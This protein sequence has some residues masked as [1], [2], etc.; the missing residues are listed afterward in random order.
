MNE[1]K[2]LVV[3]SYPPH[4]GNENP[5]WPDLAKLTV[6]TQ[7]KYC[8]KWGYDFYED[9]SNVSGK[10]RS[11]WVDDRKEG[12]APMR[13][14]IKFPLLEHFMTKEMCR[15][16]YTHVVWIDADCVVTRYDLPLTKWLQ[17][18]YQGEGAALG[19]LVLAHDVNG[20]HPTVI[21][22]RN[23][24]L[25]RGLIWACGNAGNTMFM[26][27]DWSDIMA[28]RF[29]LASPPYDHLVKFYSAKELC[30]MPPGVYTIPSDVRSQYEW[31]PESWMLHLSALSLEKR[32]EFATKAIKDLNLL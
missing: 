11:P 19:D 27:H 30:A 32:I 31:T 24:V 1:P 2:V 6:A 5:G 22:V 17:T 15:K 29:F 18:E 16:E 13:T 14:M 9:I 26:Q 28:L 7:R 4:R 8:E 20:V 10:V 3:T 12:F 25:T 23:T 21:M